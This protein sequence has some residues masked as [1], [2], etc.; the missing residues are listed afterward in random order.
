MNKL[1]VLLLT[2]VIIG[3]LIER[4]VITDN[5]YLIFLLLINMWTIW[6]A[7]KLV[8]QKKLDENTKSQ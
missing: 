1:I 4:R 8:N 2:F 7:S 5:N 3:I 6:Y